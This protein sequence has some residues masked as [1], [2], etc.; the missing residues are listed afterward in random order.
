METVLLSSGGETLLE[1]R[2]FEARPD[3]VPQISGL[4]MKSG[5]AV[6]LKGGREAKRSNRALVEILRESLEARDLP[7]DAIGLLE[8]RAAFGEMLRSPRQQN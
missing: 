5:N 6:L 1:D 8:D 4:A 3:A 7:P 2:A